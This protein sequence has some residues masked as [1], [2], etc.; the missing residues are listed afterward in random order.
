VDVACY[1]DYTCSYSYRA[2][3]LFESLRP[4]QPELT[5][6]TFLLKEVNRPGEEP[7][8]FSRGRIDSVGLLALALA[9]AS[10]T[11]DFG[12]FHATMFNAMHAENRRLSREDVCNIGADAGIDLTAF[13]RTEKKWV[14]A[15]ASEHAG[16]VNHWGVFGTPTVIIGDESALYLKLAQ[17]PS[18]ADAAAKLWEA[19]CTLAIAYPEVVEIKRPERGAT[20]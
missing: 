16:G 5:W 12:G 14:E 18:S 8:Y 13:T 11:V 9:H 20:P 1:F 17:V 6:R 10:R 4:V 15:V 2:F 7:S 19:V 3:R